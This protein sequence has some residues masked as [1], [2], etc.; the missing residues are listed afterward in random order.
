M[1]SINSYK[2]IVEHFGA[3]LAGARVSPGNI[4][5][6]MT[7]EPGQIPLLM[8]SEGLPK[9]F[10]LRTVCPERTKREGTFQ[11]VSEF[12]PAGDQPSAIHQLRDGLSSGVMHG[13]SIKNIEIT[14][15]S[16]THQTNSIMNAWCSN[17]WQMP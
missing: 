13:Y 1:Q 3:R 10:V 8:R 12:S 16:T 14:H 7:Q 6:L 9:W 2:Q 11:L 15:I 4:E 5:R 17:V